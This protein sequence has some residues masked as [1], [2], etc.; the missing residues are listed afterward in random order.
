MI[1]AGVVFSTAVY[2]LQATNDL[3]PHL[4]RKFK[5]SSDPQFEE[6][7]WDLIGPSDAAGQDLGVV[8]R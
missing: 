7:F 1:K 8:L 4:T 5:L 6:K 3:K 2:K